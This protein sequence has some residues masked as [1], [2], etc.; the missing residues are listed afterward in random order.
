MLW[1]TQRPLLVKDLRLVLALTALALFATYTE[2]AGLE[3]IDLMNSSVI[4][5]ANWWYLAICIFSND[6]GGL[7]EATFEMIEEVRAV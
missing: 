6:N 7:W 5:Y 2:V 3:G 4:R 1:A